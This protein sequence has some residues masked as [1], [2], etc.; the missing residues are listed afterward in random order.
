LPRGTR[1]SFENGKR[2][3]HKVWAPK[4][5]HGWKLYEV[6]QAKGQTGYIGGRRIKG[7]F[8]IKDPLTSKTLLEVTPRKLVRKSRP[9]QGWIVTRFAHEREKE[10]RACSPA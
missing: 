1:H 6:V 7:A 10:E 9:R 8:V 5:V 4:K 3:E 2:S